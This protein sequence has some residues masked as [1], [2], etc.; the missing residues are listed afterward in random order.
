MA[1]T[2]Q[3]IQVPSAED[4]PQAKTSRGICPPW[5]SDFMEDFEVRDDARQAQENVRLQLLENTHTEQAR[6]AAVRN[7]I[8]NV[9]PWYATHCTAWMH[10]VCCTRELRNFHTSLTA[11]HQTHEFSTT[12]KP[13]CPTRWLCRV[14]SVIAV[15]NQHEAVLCSLQWQVQVMEK[16]QPKPEDC[17]I[18]LGK[19]LQFLV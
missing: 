19:V 3:P 16:W 11:P 4:N 15:L 7:T 5:F 17:W 6:Q 14:R 18:V 13:I 10:S 8:Q 12:L 1:H 2:I 9:R